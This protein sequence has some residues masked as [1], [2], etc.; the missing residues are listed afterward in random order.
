VIDV[1]G[2][3][4]LGYQKR[5]INGMKVDPRDRERYRDAQ[6]AL[7][8]RPLGEIIEKPW[9]VAQVL[10]GP[11]ALLGANWSL[12]AAQ[13]DSPDGRESSVPISHARIFDIG[14]LYTAIAGML[15]L[16]A[17]ID[18]AARAGRDDGGGGDGGA[19]TSDKGPPQV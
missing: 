1:P 6:S 14:S 9:F 16:L 19:A 12:A 15:N 17:M 11:V 2:Y 8:A 10:A 4:N 5:V 3:D 13:P 18:S 7:S